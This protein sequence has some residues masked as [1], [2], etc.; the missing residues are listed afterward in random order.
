[1]G[2]SLIKSLIKIS[3]VRLLFWS[4]VII[5]VTN[6]DTRS[7][8][9]AEISEKKEFDYVDYE[10]EFVENELIVSFNKEISKNEVKEFL[11]DERIKKVEDIYKS[12]Y[13]DVKNDDDSVEENVKEIKQE[14][15]KTY[16]VTF[17]NKKSDDL[18]NLIEELNKNK[19]IDY[20]EPNYECTL[21]STPDE[22]TKS[23]WY[24][25]YNMDKISAEKAWD[26]ASG[27]TVYVGILDTGI[28]ASHPD[29]KENVAV[30]LGWNCVEENNINTN[31]THGHGTHVAGIVGAKGN[32]SYGIAGINWNA[33]LVP[34][35]IDRDSKGTS[36][37]NIMA[38]GILYAK[39]K[40]I[41][42]VNLSYSKSYSEIFF[43]AIEEYGESGG[44]FVTAAENNGQNNDNNSVYVRL[45]NMDNVIVVA[46]SAK[47]LDNKLC[48]ND[49]K[50]TNAG[51]ISNYGFATVD[52]AAPGQKIWS[53]VPTSCS[54]SGYCE[55]SGTSMATP[56][57]TGV[58]SLIKAKYPEYTPAMIKECIING[59][60]YEPTLG[61][62]VRSGGILNAYRA[63][64]GS[65]EEDENNMLIIQAREQ[66]T[67][68][69]SVIRTLGSKIS[70]AT[71]I[72]K[73]KIIGIKNFK[74]GKS[75]SDS[76]SNVL[77]NLQYVDLSDYSG[78][79][80]DYA[81]SNCG[82]ITD[83]TTNN[84]SLGK[85]SFFAC[86]KLEGIHRLGVLQTNKTMDVVDL[87]G[88]DGKTIIRDY[89]FTQCKSIKTV[90]LPEVEDIVLGIA[91][92]WDCYNLNTIYTENTTPEIGKAD[93][94]N[95]EVVNNSLIRRTAIQ[96]IYVRND[97]KIGARAFKDCSKLED[98][99]F[100]DKCGT[101]PTIGTDAFKGVS[102]KC[103]IHVYYPIVNYPAFMMSNALLYDGE[104]R[105]SVGIYDL[106]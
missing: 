105:V 5:T 13:L 104:N 94:M 64:N 7:V 99:F 4:L 53:T 31:D 3:K 62:C 77:K 72:T 91:A 83:I 82:K 54:A 42:I 84:K 60:T 59:V 103:T 56:H 96:A 20:A 86:T 52:I 90:C 74:D 23:T 10:N 78:E 18:L 87:S 43:D 38:R 67:I 26:I 36:N 25:H 57:V 35:K 21:E 14:I 89:C 40:N 88:I 49:K 46:A 95:L 11:S 22:Y 75:T 66:D 24:D 39:S 93:L 102:S 106:N 69:E 6:A 58:A 101:I 29:L 16:I 9:A 80:G 65:T 17:R 73:L 28:D 70:D 85:R 68:R 92:F 15:G 97:T 63:L 32:N 50:D 19:M 30:D 47:T 12:V 55:M 41:P 79:I 2:K 61:S 27:N 44:L 71:Q 34:L 100:E 48:N 8:L 1:M 81:F 98:V 76:V 51:Y 33:K 37:V 45:A